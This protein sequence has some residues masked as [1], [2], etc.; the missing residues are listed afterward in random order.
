MIR[1]ILMYLD[2]IYVRNANVAPICLL[3]LRIFRKEIVDFPMINDHLHVI[4]GM[5][6][7]NRQ[8]QIE[9]W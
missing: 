3:G 8:K 1:D 4:L 2:R 5:I 9:D 7:L 6:S